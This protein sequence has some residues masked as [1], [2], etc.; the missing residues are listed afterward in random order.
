MVGNTMKKIGQ[1]E[2]EWGLA[3]GHRP[4]NI[5]HNYRDLGWEIRI[6][7][8]VSVTLK[9]CAF[10]FW[11]KLSITL[12]VT[13]L[14]EWGSLAKFNCICESKN[15]T[16]SAEIICQR[17]AMFSFHVQSSSLIVWPPDWVAWIEIKVLHQTHNAVCIASI[18]PFW[19]CFAGCFLMLS[20]FF[21]LHECVSSR[22]TA[23]HVEGLPLLHCASLTV[24][25][26]LCLLE[27]SPDCYPLTL[28]ASQFFLRS[29]R[30]WYFTDIH[31]IYYSS[32]LSNQLKPI[33]SLTHSWVRWQT[34]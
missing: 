22:H 25:L 28:M 26:S 6:T 11:N 8:K 10:S 2:R 30:R 4:L 14:R 7:K 21:L 13:S 34:N 9:S 16:V 5:S 17:Q 24:P 23:G 32:N 31:V 1:Q 29:Q 27:A 18:L 12:S 33:N 15:R 3:I 20:L 19:S